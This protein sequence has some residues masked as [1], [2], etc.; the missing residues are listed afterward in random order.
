[1]LRIEVSHD[2]KYLYIHLISGLSLSFKIDD[3]KQ[4]GSLQQNQPIA[5]LQNE[6]ILLRYK[7][8]QDSP[9]LDINI[10]YLD[11]SSI[12]ISTTTS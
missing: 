6:A 1:M 3:G 5:L 8:N 12:D 4:F 10:H 9:S 7:P 2:L 11:N